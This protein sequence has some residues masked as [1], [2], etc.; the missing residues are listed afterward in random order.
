MRNTIRV[1]TGYSER[2]NIRYYRE[3][4]I[5]DKLPSLDD[6]SFGGHYRYK[7]ENFKILEI[8][9]AYIDCEQSDE[10]YDYE[11]YEIVIQ[12]TNDDGKIEKETF[13]VAIEI[14]WD[15]IIQADEDFED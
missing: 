2:K 11:Y 9:S 8:R 15:A 3:F 14:D 1:C 6:D 10:V 13:E 7:D 12:Y 4:V 5:I